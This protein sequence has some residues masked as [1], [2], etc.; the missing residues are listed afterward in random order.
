MDTGEGSAR[1]QS[2]FVASRAPWAIAW[3]F[4][5]AILGWFALRADPAVRAGNDIFFSDKRWRGYKPIR[6][7]LWMF[8]EV[9]IMSGDS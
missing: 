2:S 9:A 5:Q 1:P 4:A 7:R 3:N 6:N 8:N